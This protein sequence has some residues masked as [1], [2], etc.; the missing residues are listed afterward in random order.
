MTMKFWVSLALLAGIGCSSAVRPQAPQ[1]GRSF[2]AREMVDRLRVETSWQPPLTG[3]QCVT[4]WYELPYGS[5]VAQGWTCRVPCGWG[6]AVR[7]SRCCRP[8]PAI[9]EW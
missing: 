4:C 8:L 1:P 7:W 6:R 3:G 9:P 5:Y 2:E